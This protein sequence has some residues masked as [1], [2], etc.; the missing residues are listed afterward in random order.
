MRDDQVASVRRAVAELHGGFIRVDEPLLVALGTL[1]NRRNLGRKRLE[2]RRDAS[3]RV[4]NEEMVPWR[5]FPVHARCGE[6]I[7]KHLVELAFDEGVDAVARPQP[8]IEAQ[9]RQPVQ[10]K[11]SVIVARNELGLF[12]AFGMLLGE[13]DQRLVVPPGGAEQ[14]RKPGR[15]NPR[16]HVIP[17]LIRDPLEAQDCRDP[18]VLVPLLP[19]EEYLSRVVEVAGRQRRVDDP[20]RMQVEPP[21]LIVVWVRAPVERQ[22]EGDGWQRRYRLEGFDRSGPGFRVML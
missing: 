11:Q 16:R 19:V 17:G 1:D 21:I 22:L 10:L 8:A 12:E 14:V 7:A 4:G 5:V 3:E 20:Q 6:L 18:A 13:F 9:R 15:P 2:E